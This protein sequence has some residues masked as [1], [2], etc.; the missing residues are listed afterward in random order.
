[1]TKHTIIKKR[2]ER[3]LG[4]VIRQGTKESTTIAGSK[5]IGGEGERA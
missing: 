4:L 5:A 3:M 2:K 1:M